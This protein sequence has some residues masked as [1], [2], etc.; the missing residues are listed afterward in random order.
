MAFSFLFSF[1][2]YFP[3]V[4]LQPHVVVVLRE[5]ADPDQIAEE[6]SEVRKTIDNNGGRKR[7]G[8]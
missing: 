5:I 4:C 7:K 3:D 1:L 8:K 2:F 6:L